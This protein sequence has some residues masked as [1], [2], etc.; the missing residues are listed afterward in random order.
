MSEM[1]VLGP[2]VAFTI[3]APIVLV[4]ILSRFLRAREDVPLEH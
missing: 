4:A 1:I 3:L 2:V